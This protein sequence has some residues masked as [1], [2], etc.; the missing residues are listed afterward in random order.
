MASR[1]EGLRPIEQVRRSK[2]RMARKRP[3]TLGRPAS[4]AALKILKRVYR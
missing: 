4:T 3:R 1:F 2:H